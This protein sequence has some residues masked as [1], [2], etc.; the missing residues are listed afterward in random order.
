MT[1]VN[2]KLPRSVDQT[3]VLFTARL[4]IAPRRHLLGSVSIT[5]ALSAEY[6]NEHVFPPSS[7]LTTH[8]NLR[9]RHSASFAKQTDVEQLEQLNDDAHSSILI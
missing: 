8:T 3:L 5:A 7:S 2:W 6:A 1:A 4:P 9:Y